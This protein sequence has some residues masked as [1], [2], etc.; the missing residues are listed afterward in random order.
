MT[1]ARDRLIPNEERGLLGISAHCHGR[2][3]NAQQIHQRRLQL[4]VLGVGADAIPM[5]A[6]E[7]RQFAASMV[8]VQ[9]QER[10]SLS[11]F[12]GVAGHAISHYLPLDGT[13]FRNSPTVDVR[14]FVGSATVGGSLRKGRLMVSL[15]ATISSRAFDGQAGG[16]EFGTLSVSWHL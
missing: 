6:R 11:F 12:G 4:F 8:G 1:E 14:P 5:H 2:R 3:A 15:A 10:W 9:P 16:A 7:I 13:V